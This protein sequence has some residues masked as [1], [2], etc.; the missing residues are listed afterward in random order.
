MIRQN[1]K[2]IDPDQWLDE[3]Q[4]TELPEIPV[5]EAEV[6]VESEVEDP[7]APEVDTGP[8]LDILIVPEDPE[9]LAEREGIHA[10]IQVEIQHEDKEAEVLAEEMLEAPL[11]WN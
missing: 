3:G 4:L 10:R 5:E 1:P 2:D 6:W 11:V 8:G 9:V 7:K